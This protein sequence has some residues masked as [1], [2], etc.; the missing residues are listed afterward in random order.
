M[1]ALLA[2]A[3]FA[4]ALTDGFAAGSAWVSK[5]AIEACSAPAC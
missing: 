3:F 2:L 1:R 4:I 5:P